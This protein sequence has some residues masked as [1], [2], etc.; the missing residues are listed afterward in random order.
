[1]EAATAAQRNAQPKIKKG[2]VRRESSA[3]ISR[4]LIEPRGVDED[5]ERRCCALEAEISGQQS[6]NNS[7]ICLVGSLRKAIRQVAR[8]VEC[9]DGW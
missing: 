6:S 7:C 4:W 9:E 5:W 2:G 1:M 3:T 8:P